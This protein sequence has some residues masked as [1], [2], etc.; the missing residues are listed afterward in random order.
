[1]GH[2]DLQSFF[3]WVVGDLAINQLPTM[4]VALALAL[5]FTILRAKPRRQIRLRVLIR[6]LFPKRLVMSPTGRADIAFF[7][8]GYVVAALLFGWTLLSKGA[9]QN[10]AERLI[11]G[12][13]AAGAMHDMSPAV[14]TVLE[15]FIFYLSYEFGY[16]L[17]H[18][19]KHKVKFLWH[20]HAVHHSAE[21][22]SPFTNFRV[23]PV[24]SV[25]FAN[26]LALTAG[27]SGAVTH[28]L[29][30]GPIH[31]ITIRGGNALIFVFLL[32][33]ST[34]QHSHLWISFSGKLGRLFLSPAH[35]QI[36][37]ST[38]ARHFDKNFGSTLALFDWLFGTLHIPAA[39]REKFAFGVEGLRSPHGF[40]GA[41]LDPFTASVA[42]LKRRR[43]APEAASV[44]LETTAP[45]R[46]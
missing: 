26:I 33:L 12:A 9:V 45:L 24:D 11:A 44:S 41:L 25:I 29:I 10:V 7:A 31:Q 8:G 18:Y 32:L 27:L 1:M 30:G 35:H 36:H 5:A 34:L 13:P 39:R 4:F 14:A 42:E 22:L 21:S 38:E 37:H 20:F 3:L 6:A 15:T 28:H 46:S 17:D 40:K 16:W 23:H 43:H 2:L 19:L